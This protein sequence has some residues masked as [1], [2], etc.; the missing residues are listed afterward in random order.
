MRDGFRDGHY[1][2]PTAARAFRHPRA[3]AGNTRAP[4]ELD[5]TDRARRT[6]K[7]IL[8]GYLVL[9]VYSAVSWGAADEM[10]H[11]PGAT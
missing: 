5:P 7:R 9:V 6:M 2:L 11:R 3:W 4:S 1:L 10:R 8:S